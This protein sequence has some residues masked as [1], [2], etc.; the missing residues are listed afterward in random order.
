GQAAL[1]GAIC[2]G[3]DA[4]VVLVAAAVEH[5]GVDAGRLGALGEPLAGGVGLLERLEAAQVTLGPGDGGQRAAGVVVDELGE[6]APVGA[7]HGDA[8]TLGRAVDL[9]PDA[10]APLQAPR[11]C[12]RDAHARLPT[13]RATYSPW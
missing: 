8:R 9:G 13:F 10:P 2:Q 1:T 12:G 11:G 6:D 7:E 5:R 3:L 4:A